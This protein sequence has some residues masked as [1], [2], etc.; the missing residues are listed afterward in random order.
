[1]TLQ[2]TNRQTFNRDRCR[3]A[4]LLQG[5]H[6]KISFEVASALPV[7]LSPRPGPVAYCR[8]AARYRRSSAHSRCLA[9]KR[10]AC[11]VGGLVSAIAVLLYGLNRSPMSYWPS[12]FLRDGPLPAKRRRRCCPKALSYSYVTCLRLANLPA[13]LW[14][15]VARVSAREACTTASRV[16]RFIGNPGSAVHLLQ[17][18][19]C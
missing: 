15:A 6:R 11:R 7:P 18:L 13:T 14:R 9:S 19:R 3:K 4:I 8:S 1:V 16:A 12:R 5:L 2:P 17:S 10:A